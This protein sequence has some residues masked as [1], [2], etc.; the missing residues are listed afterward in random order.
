[1]GGTRS[2]PAH[3]VSSLRVALTASPVVTCSPL[4][5]FLYIRRRMMAP[6]TGCFCFIG[7]YFS[8]LFVLQHG[9]LLGPVLQWGVHVGIDGGCPLP[10]RVPGKGWGALGMQC[11]SLVGG[12]VIKG[13]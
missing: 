13:S 9:S 12:S 4:S 1:M 6:V 7:V 8:S 2:G 5:A 11:G 10:M 3:A